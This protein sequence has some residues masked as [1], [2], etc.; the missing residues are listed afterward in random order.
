VWTYNA[1]YRA[2][3]GGYWFQNTRFPYWAMLA[4]GDFGNMVPLFEMYLNAV[5]LLESRTQTWFGHSGAFFSE[6][7]YFWG[8]YLDGDYGCGYNKQPLWQINN[9]WMRYHINGQLELLTMLLAHYEYTGDQATA[10]KYLLPL[11]SSILNFFDNHYQNDLNGHKVLSPSQSIET[12]QEAINPLPDLAG[13]KWSLT[14]LLELPFITPSQKSS[15]SYLLGVLPA[16]PTGSN[17]TAPV[18]LP[19]ESWLANSLHNSE[20]PELYAIF[21]FPLYGVGLPNISIAVNSYWNRK[22]HCD[23]GWCQDVLIAA[24]LGLTSQ[25][26]RSLEQ[27]LSYQPEQYGFRFPTFLGKFFDY[28]PEEDHTSVGQLAIQY[29]LLQ[30][31][32]NSILLFPA[33]PAG[34]DVH[35]KLFTAQQTSVEVI[36][37]SGKIT[38][39]TVTPSS[40]RNDVQ[41]IGSSCTL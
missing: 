28:P 39:L 16:I 37:Q 2:W 30:T 22:F 17:G 21:P 24:L 6:T 41:I 33:W 3:G 34:W 31:R 15:W 11:A 23:V 4:N 20:N 13:L 36:C 14:Q 5:P 38:L 26:E 35:F 1:D 32:G 27:R 25:A 18:L 8:T 12:W 9:Q 19:A 7:L 10:Q 40:R 29:M